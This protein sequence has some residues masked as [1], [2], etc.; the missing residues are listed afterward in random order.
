MEFLKR[1]ILICITLLIMGKISAQNG[2]DHVFEFLNL[3]SS[4]LVTSLGGANVSLPSNDLNLAYENP[5]LLA[6]GMNRS[7]ALNYVNYFSDINYGLVMYSGAFRT[8]NIAGGLTYLNYGSFNATDP[9][10]MVTGKFSAAEYAFSLIVSREIDSAFSFGI[11]IKPVLSQLERY[12]SF[13]LAFDIGGSWHSRSNNLI[14]GIVARN[15]GLQLDSYAGEPRQKLPFELMA[16]IS[17]RLTYAPLRLSLTVRNLQTFDLSKTEETVSS[18]A[19]T[20]SKSG[21]TSNILKHVIPGVEIIPHK[22]FYLAAG[23]NFRR[24]ME[25]KTSSGGAPGFTW[26]FGI[27]TDWLDLEF[28]RAVFHVAGA[29]TNLSL[30]LRTDRIYRKDR[31]N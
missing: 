13:G 6:S 10:G 16:G 11:T 14:T 29:S 12:S 4:G 27:I 1:A 3:T 21:F 7:L 26:G 18:G 2:G 31:N 22:N 24:S 23:Y 5:A 15:A 8:F 28:G 9:T 25:L 30:I 17:H 20:Q 19:S